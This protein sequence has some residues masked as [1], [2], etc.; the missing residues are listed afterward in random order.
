M[1]RGAYTAKQ[2][3]KADH[4]EEGYEKRGV[5]KKEA[6]ERAWRTVNKQDK[7]GKN[8][9][10]GRSPQPQRRRQE[11]LGDA[12]P[13]R[14]RLSSASRARGFRSRVRARAARCARAARGAS[15]ERRTA[16]RLAQMLR[17]PPRSAAARGGGDCRDRAVRSTRP[18]RTSASTDAADRRRAAPDRCGDLVEGRRLVRADRA[19]AARAAARSA[20][21]AAAVRRPVARPVARSAPR[22]R[23]VSIPQ[24]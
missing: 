1:P 19:T 18:A 14:Q 10:S 9:G 2:E 8:D 21:S 13:P 7:G 15:S 11:G 20:R 3:R 6:E 17:G 24:T 22:A 5:A 23:P 4:I 12:P 16:G